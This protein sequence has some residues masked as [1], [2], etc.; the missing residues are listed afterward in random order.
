MSLR[1]R[2]GNWHYRFF[3]AGRTWTADTGLA[4]TERNR[5]AALMAEVEARKLIDEGRPGQLKIQPK[6][7]SDAADQFIEWAKGEHRHKKETWKRLRGSMTSLKLYFNLRPLHTITVGQVQDYMSWRRLCPACSGEGCDACDH[8][9]QGVKE[10]TLRH[11]LHALSPLFK[12]GLD[13]NWCSLNPVERVKMPTDAD[14]V[15]MHV[16]TSAE[17]RRYFETC[18]RL[19]AE[20]RASAQRAKGGAIAAKQRAAQ[21]FENLHDLGRLMVLQGPRPSEVMAARVEHLDMARGEWLIAAGKSRAARRVLDLTPESL[22]ILQKRCM[23]AEPDGFVFHGRNRGTPLSDVENAHKRV[24]AASGLALVIYDLR[25]TFATRFAE[26]TNGDVVALAA[27]LGHANLRTVMRYVHVS[28]EHRRSQMRRF[29][30]AEKIRV[31][32]GSNGSAENAR[33][34]QTNAK[35]NLPLTSSIQ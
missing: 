12:Y 3:A 34:E 30:E 18:K 32:S 7:F 11:D 15:R 5:N 24:L 33:S 21:C 23:S 17:E 14:A 8:T 26:A 19:A 22:A 25:H 16:L 20:L 9:G 4:A 29:V 1:K 13:H 10:I 28:R 27:I 31:K 35:D 6:P 2:S